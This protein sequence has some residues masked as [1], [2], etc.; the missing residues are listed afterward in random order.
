MTELLSVDISYFYGYINFILIK[1]MQ[2]KNTKTF[3]RSLIVFQTFFEVGPSDGRFPVWIP[4]FLGII[5]A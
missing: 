5:T 3:P 2:L 1:F 4:S